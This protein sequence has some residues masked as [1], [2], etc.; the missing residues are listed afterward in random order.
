LPAEGRSCLLRNVATPSCTPC[1]RQ[2]RPPSPSWPDPQR[3]TGGKQSKQPQAA[4]LGHCARRE[5]FE[6]PT[7][8]SVVIRLPY[9]ARCKTSL[10]ES[11]SYSACKASSGISL[12]RPVQRMLQGTDRVEG[13]GLLDASRGGTSH[14]GHS[15]ALLAS[16]RADEA[17]ALPITGGCVVLPARAV[18]RPPPTPCWLAVP[19]PVARL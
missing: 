2:G 7:P 10:R 11:L 1:W 9:H 3:M 13:L 4:D 18:L 12:G 17:A 16:L 5:G 6:P 14:D 15:P 8:R 19:F